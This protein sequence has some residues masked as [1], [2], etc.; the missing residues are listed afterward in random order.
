MIWPEKDFPDV[1]YSLSRGEFMK[2]CD[3]IDILT[4][5]GQPTKKYGLDRL[6][7][8]FWEMYIV[9]SY[10]AELKTIDIVREIFLVWLIGSQF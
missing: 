7:F 10:V 5:S 6:T 8:I 3:F 2:K 9:Q 1:V 4:I